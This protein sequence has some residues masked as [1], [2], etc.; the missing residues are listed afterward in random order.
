MARKLSTNCINSIWHW[1][2]YMLNI[3]AHKLVVNYEYNIY[4]SFAMQCTCRYNVHMVVY[5]NVT[6][7]VQCIML[8]I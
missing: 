3:C 4:T 8:V 6:M 7:R 2:G 5:F 1:S